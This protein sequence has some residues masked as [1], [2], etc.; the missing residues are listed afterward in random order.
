MRP[1]IREIEY[2]LLKLGLP[3]SLV[4]RHISQIR[5]WRRHHPEDGPA[6]SP[7]GVP[8]QFSDKEMSSPSMTGRDRGSPSHRSDE[9]SSWPMK[10][11]RGA[12]RVVL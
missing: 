1:D 4:E 11:A 3:S 6:P 7:S 12:Y 8:R 10:F 9:V 2:R 5:R